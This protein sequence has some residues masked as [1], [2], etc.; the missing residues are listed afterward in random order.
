MTSPG[1]EFWVP[2]L[3]TAR[4]QAPLAGRDLL[5]PSGPGPSLLLEGTDLD[6]L[7]VTRRSARPPRTVTCAK[8]L[9]VITAHAPELSEVLATGRA[10]PPAGRSCVW[11]AL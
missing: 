4:G 1:Q 7:A 9:D 2:G 8:A 5:D 11:T 6:V 10:V 3:P